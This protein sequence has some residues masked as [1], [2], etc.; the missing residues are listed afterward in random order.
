MKNKLTV[1]LFLVLLLLLPAPCRASSPEIVGK[2][3][4]VNNNVMVNLFIQ[5]LDELE[6]LMRSGIEK[7]VIFT[8]ELLRVWKFWPDEFVVSK[9]IVKAIKYDNLRDHYSLSLS[10]GV[11]RKKMTLKDYDAVKKW[12]FVVSNVNLANIRELVPSEYYVRIIVE[13]RSLE[14]LPFLGVLTHLLPEVEMSLAK[15]SQPFTIG[16]PE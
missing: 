6:Y 13:S 14:Q 4:I 1:T 7:E 15:E 11:T 16:A 2:M 8:V 10:D 5:N 9:K 3:D 12:M